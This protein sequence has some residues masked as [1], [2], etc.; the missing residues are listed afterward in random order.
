MV[1]LGNKEDKVKLMPSLK[2]HIVKPVPAYSNSM[3]WHGPPHPPSKMREGVNI[4][5]KNQLGRNQKV[6][7]LEEGV[8]SWG[9]GQFFWWGGGGQIIFFG[10]GDGKLHNQNIYALKGSICTEELIRG[11]RVTHQCILRK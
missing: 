5:E 3:A 9:V 1:C 11:I 8:V 7:S 2:Q 10:G 6:L 4:F